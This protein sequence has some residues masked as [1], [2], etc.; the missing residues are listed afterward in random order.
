M[1]EHVEYPGR[2]L[3]AMS[4]AVNYHKW[5]LDEFRPFLGKRV[6]EVGAG[7]GSFSEM[8]N[9][10]RI[11]RLTLIEPSAMFDVLSNV[12]I[13]RDGIEI[14]FEQ[15]LFAQVCGKVAMRD[16]PDSII[17]VN[18]LEHV[19]H[20]VTE[21]KLIHK[22]LAP[23]GRCLIFVP[24]L[25]SLYGKFDERIGH[26]RRYAKAEIEQK[27]EEA[28]FT[29]LLSK[30]FDIAGIIPWWIK[31][32]LLGSDSL[33]SGAVTFYDKFAVPV[34]RLIESLVKPPVGKNILIVCKKIPT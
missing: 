22:T 10:E 30:Y 27:C 2:D 23:G 8:L 32:K 33:E 12:I 29:V 11:D 24:A 19:E 25:M 26:F 14:N 20:D 7:T 3:E 21:L 9:G 18:V 31:Y 17:Y 34:T 5:I 28:G 16:K 1:T 15:A 4:F 13:G 6:V